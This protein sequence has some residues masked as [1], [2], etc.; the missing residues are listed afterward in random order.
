MFLCFLSKP[1]TRLSLVNPLCISGF[2][3]RRGLNP[4]EPT[5]A[6]VSKEMEEQ[7]EAGGDADSQGKTRGVRYIT[8]ELLL[9]LSGC[10]S[11][12]LIHSLN[13]SSST[14]DKHIKFIENLHNC[15]HLQVLNLNYN[16][17]ERIEKL[18][19]LTQLR[20]LHLAHNNIQRIEG[21]ELLSSLQ[22]LNLSYNR[23]EHVP[24]WMGKKLHS[25]HTLHLQHN[26]ITSLYE[27]SRLRALSSLSELS[28]SGNPASSLPHSRLF[29]LFHLRTL[30]RL[31]DLPITQEEKGHAYQRF[32]TEELERM[33]HEIDSNQS[34][35]S[36]L[37][38][39][40]HAAVTR[41]DQQEETN[42]ALMAQSQMQ[43]HTYRLLEQELHTKSQL[44]DKTTAELTRAFQ[45]LY[46]LEQELTFHKIDT[47]LSPLPP[48]SIQVVDAG[49]SPA[50]S[51][52]IG[53]ARHIRNIITS[54]PRNCSSSSPRSSLQIQEAA[55]IHTDMESL[56][57]SLV[58]VYRAPQSTGDAELLQ[59]THQS[60]Q[61]LEV[62]PPNPEETKRSR[63][64]VQCQL[65]SKLSVLGE[66]KDEADEARR[67]MD[68]QKEESRKIKRETEELETQL[69]REDATDQE[70]AHVTTQLSS[71]RQ[72]LDRMSRKQIEL[73][74]RLD[75]MLSRIAIE[76]QEIKEL[77]QQLTDG[78]IL[79][80]EALQ[81]D[82]EEI[83]S[84][85]QEYLRGLRD[86]AHCAQQ[87]VDKL[88]AENQ[89]LQLH[90]EDTQRHC[91]HLED[92]TTTH[93]QNMSTQQEE[94]SVL[95]MEAEALRDRQVEGKKHQVELEA[96]LHQLRAELTRQVTVGQLEC[97]ALQAAVDKEKQI[98]E[99]R[100]SQLQSTID[101]LQDEKLSL[102]EIAQR[103]Q[104]QLDQTKAQLHQT[105]TQYKETRTHLDQT[106]IQLDQFTADLLNLQEVLSGPEELDE[107][108]YSPISPDIL[109][110]RSVEQLYRT[111]QQT[112]TS[113]E[114]L[115]LD[116]NHSQEQIA[117]LQTQLA[118][119]QDHIAQLKVQLAQNKET[120]SM[121]QDQDS[122]CRLKEELERLR[123]KLQRTE[124]RNGH[125]QQNLQS[126]LEQSHLQLQD[127]QQ[128]RDKLLQQL[129][130]Q[131]DG[132]ERN[133]SRLNRKL[134]QL[135]KFMCDCDQLT[136]EQL[137]STV[138]QLR[139]LNR[140]VELLATQ[141]SVDD[142]SSQPAEHTHILQDRDTVE[143]LRTQ[144]A[145][146]QRQAH[147][148]RQQLDKV[149]TRNE[150]GTG[151][152]SGISTRDGGQWCF[153]PP[154]HSSHSLGSQGTQ[155]SGLGLHYLNSPDRGQQQQ[156]PPVEGG[157]WVYIP[158]TQTNSDK[159]TGWRDSGGGSD[160]DRSSTGG[161]P[162]PPPDPAA[163]VSVRPAWLLCGSP[164]A[165]VYSPPAEGGFLHCNVPEHRDTREKCVCEHKEAE[166]L[167]EEKKK[168]RLETKQL[169]RSL[170]RHRSAM[171][172]C[173]EVDCVEKTLLK[174]RAELRHAD[175]L[176]LEAQSCI[177]TTRDKATSAQWTA[178]MLQ[179]RAQDNTTCVEEDTQHLSALQE[180]VEDLRKRRQQE[181]QTLRE[182]QEVLRNRDQEFQQLGTKIHSATD[183]LSEIL[184]D[185]Q[186]AQRRLD[187]V[188][189]QV[190]QQE[191][192]LIQRSEEQR[193]ALNKVEELRIEEQRLHNRVKELMEQQEELLQQRRSTVSAVREEEQKLLTVQSELN[194]HR[195]EL[196]QVLRELLV[197]Q[198][199]LED[200]KPKFTQTL[201]RLHKKKGE[202]HRMKDEL[203][204]MMDELESNQD[205]LDRKQ[206][207][208]DGIQDEVDK[209]KDELDK[210]QREVDRKMEE[211]EKMQDEVNRKRKEL[212]VLQ[213]EAESHRK[214]SESCLKNINQQ[215]S[216][217]QMLQEELSSRREERTSI[218]EQ[219]KHLEAR[220]RHADRCLS[221]VE[222]ELAKQ[223]EEHSHTQLL[224]QEMVR[225]TAANQ[226]QLHESS[227][228]LSLLAERVEE[229][230]KQL[231]A[232]DQDLSTSAQQQQQ[233]EEQLKELDRQIQEKQVA[234]LGLD[235]VKAAACQLEHKGHRLKQLGEELLH[236]EEALKQ[237]REE[238]LM[239]EESL[240]QIEERLQKKCEELYIKLDKH[241]KK[242]EELRKKDVSEED[243]SFY[244]ST[245]G[246]RTTF[247]TGDD[248][249]K[250][251]LQREE[252][253]QQ[254][255]RL[256]AR[257]RCTLWN[258]QENLKVR[259]L[260]T[261]ESLL[262]LKVRLDQLDS[263]LTH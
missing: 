71:C 65:F 13:L 62:E 145:E 229:R 246:A 255:D 96:E 102:Q 39:E 14:G 196:K 122:E 26:H 126:Q 76:T 29:L 85:L 167:E 139:A 58:E 166:K 197:E 119:D 186:E 250:V 219:C 118:Q 187:A 94:L 79:V 170:R 53:K 18:S 24:V 109:L 141:K 120:R 238:L 108:Q 144:L 22:H 253:R 161:T 220:R 99:I 110:S 125:I 83:I 54:T 195:A 239:K 107:D 97:D 182:V 117:K 21:L 56:Q 171:Q 200:I 184:S 89:S 241:Q 32:S 211:L 252:L 230:K 181:E 75:D 104:T 179:R 12:A 193:E 59:L 123:G 199:A 7:S 106:R 19:T 60:E 74:G 47:K 202:L 23:I 115:Q 163:D 112:R 183:R 143:E 191:Q 15:Q 210:K 218:Q 40:H 68:G 91:R 61:Q 201:Q 44:L 8:E 234:C 224:K 64:E 66:L 138:E 92:I 88:Q 192:R 41:L 223:K 169:R 189:I 262:E 81:R 90:L 198:Q 156:R 207:E 51:P 221:A 95:Q 57:C 50:E 254:E 236:K 28:V 153:V 6:N 258:Q 103:L 160:A 1:T 111:I 249:W 227:E 209:K 235:D 260:E 42:R 17:I 231:Q 248:R 86:Q 35:L 247:S 49:D 124:S 257:L 237:Q 217:L 261:E 213:Q 36:R 55:D 127:V 130:S 132:H 69:L 3:W 48:C 245:A 113:R 82:L 80:N 240:I 226:E 208:V 174:R 151:T 225:D 33:Q 216:E 101:T 149:R 228:L 242:E 185:C 5:L 204:R 25:L 206:E 131:T 37:Q 244:L 9:K 45:K 215:R 259:R 2:P 136:A 155:D 27:M 158:P 203:D 16:M 243:E 168:L 214:E 157:Y 70:H 30:D 78:Q 128:E 233:R 31:D 165:I 147:R 140:T 135:S 180:D 34:E 159:A 222:V 205:K 263:L 152:R 146:A 134:R 63:Q 133:L 148:L 100:E 150:I 11:L 67:Q 72:L 162:L 121:D 188:N 154:G 129:R 77:E 87:Q 38:G 142:P 73:E 43:Q 212:T 20:E 232:L 98:R 52:Y 164:A 137:K 175:R 93:R 46:E 173:D 114:Q 10:R 190:E 4:N 178:D 251:E 177:H 105:R 116:H 84:G 176:L 172:V 194:T 256:K